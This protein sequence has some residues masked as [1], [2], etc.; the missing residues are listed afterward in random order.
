MRKFYKDIKVIKSCLICGAVFR[1]PRGDGNHHGF[2]IKH[3]SLYWRSW[4]EKYGKKLDRKKYK[5]AQDRAW[6][7]WVEKH[8]ERRR[9]QALASYHRRKK[10][11]ST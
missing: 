8:K 3:R 1:P 9:A 10:F 2:C 7:N 4:Y 11:K 5:E 6:K